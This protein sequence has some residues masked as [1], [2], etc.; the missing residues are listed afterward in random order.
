MVHNISL[1]VSYI[2]GLCIWLGSLLFFQHNIPVQY[3]VSDL[4]APHS[5]NNNSPSVWR[6]PNKLALGLMLQDRTPAIWHWKLILIQPRIHIVISLF[7]FCANHI[8]VCFLLNGLEQW[9]ASNTGP[10]WPDMKTAAQWY[11]CCNSR[12]C[13]C[14]IL[15][16]HA[17]GMNSLWLFPPS[18]F[19]FSL[20]SHC[21][22]TEYTGLVSFCL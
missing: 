4:T 5:E 17:D 13:R 18:L 9:S 10:A 21:A 3:A 15:N 1:P 20:L 19:S 16:Q 6:N 14:D 11:A 22:G 12:H 8:H 2:V 7:F